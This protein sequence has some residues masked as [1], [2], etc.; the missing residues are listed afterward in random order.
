M[1]I[2][3]RDVSIRER[4]QRANQLLGSTLVGREEAVEV[5]TQSADPW[6]RSCAAYAI[7]ELHPVS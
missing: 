2:I 6:L 7:G 5:L 3:D 4:I 1:P